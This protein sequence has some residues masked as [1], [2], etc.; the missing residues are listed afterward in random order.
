[1]RAAFLGPI[2]AVLMTYAQ[3]PVVNEEQVPRWL[4]FTMIMSVYPQFVQ[5]TASIRIRGG[6][7]ARRGGLAPL[8]LQPV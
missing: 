3:F 7:A 1:V 4:Q 8:S 6:G 2:G 5:V